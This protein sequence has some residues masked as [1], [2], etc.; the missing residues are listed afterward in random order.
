MYC[1]LLICLSLFTL[2]TIWWLSLKPSQIG[3]C[4]CG[5]NQVD[6]DQLDEDMPHGSLTTRRQTLGGIVTLT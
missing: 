6:V 1:F 5:G 4:Q 3:G 2:I